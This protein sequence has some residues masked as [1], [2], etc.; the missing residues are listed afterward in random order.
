V[1]DLAHE[2]CDGKWI[3]LGGGGYGVV[4]CVPR[5]WTHLIAEASGDRLRP[6]TEVPAGWRDDVRRRGLRAEPP[7]TMTEGGY[8]GFARWDPFTE[9]RVDRA[10]TRT[11]TASFPYFGLDPDDPRD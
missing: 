2:V 1:H 8:V 6:D 4:R 5:A 9:S 11:R 10:I 3:A 7:E